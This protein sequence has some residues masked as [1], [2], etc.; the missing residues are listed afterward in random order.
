VAALHGL[1]RSQ[2]GVVLEQND[3]APMRRSIRA[4]HQLGLWQELQDLL[5]CL[6]ELILQGEDEAHLRRRLQEL[7]NSDR[8]PKDRMAPLRY[9]LHVAGGWLDLGLTAQAVRV[10]DEVWELLLV[11]GLRAGQTRLSWAYARTLGRLPTDEGLRRGEEVFQ[12]LGGAIDHFSTDSHYVFAA[13]L[14]VES[15]VLGM[16]AE[17]EGKA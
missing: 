5:S 9:L 11:G 6:G 15:L 12:Q 3:D 10:L 14:L 1:L 4:L 7:S 8:K 17:A 13:L 2:E 16:T